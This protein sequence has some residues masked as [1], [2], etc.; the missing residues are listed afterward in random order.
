MEELDAYLQETIDKREDENEEVEREV[1]IFENA[2]DFSDTHLR[3]C[4]VPRNEIVAVD[5]N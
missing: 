5:I 3:D 4:M 1:K 2:L